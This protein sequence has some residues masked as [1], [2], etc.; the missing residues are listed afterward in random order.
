MRPPIKKVVNNSFWPRAAA[1]LHMPEFVGNPGGYEVARR[2]LGHSEL[3]HTINM[4]SGMETRTAWRAIY[5]GLGSGQPT[6]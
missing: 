6:S 4:Y 3:S 5:A 2:L 1:K